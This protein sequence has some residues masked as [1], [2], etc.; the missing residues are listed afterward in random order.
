MAASTTLTLRVDPDLKSKAEA[1]VSQLGLTLSA[2]VNVFLNQVVREQAIPF[3]L[4]VDPFYSDANLR[5][6]RH[7]LD[8]LDQGK[9][10][11]KTLED[12]KALA[13]G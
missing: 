10:V 12:L 1:V 9:V 8:Q 2:A 3:R 4:A 11:V 6:I 5:H 7:S 13:Q